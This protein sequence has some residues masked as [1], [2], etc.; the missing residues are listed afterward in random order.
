[1]NHKPIQLE[2]GVQSVRQRMRPKLYARAR[3]YWQRV[4]DNERLQLSDQQLN[5]QFWLFDEEGIPR[6]K[7]DQGRFVLSPDPLLA[8]AEAAKKAGISSST[9]DLSST[10]REILQSRWTPAI[11]GQVTTQDIDEKRSTD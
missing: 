11:Q 8:M 1:M 9:G 4:G 5:Q 6:L 10:S 2:T 7:S 3:E